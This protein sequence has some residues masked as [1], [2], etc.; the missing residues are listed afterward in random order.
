MLHKIELK[1]VSNEDAIE[2]SFG[3]LDRRS[4]AGIAITAK[5]SVNFRIQSSTAGKLKGSEPENFTLCKAVFLL[6]LVFL[7]VYMKIEL[8]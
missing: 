3:T 7:T 2:A 4:F 5:R 6:A 8:D 1:Y